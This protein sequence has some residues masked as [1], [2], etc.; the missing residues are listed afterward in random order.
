MMQP[1]QTPSSAS[2]SSETQPKLHIHFRF[3][4]VFLVGA[5]IYAVFM[6]GFLV[7]VNRTIKPSQAGAPTPAANTADAVSK[8]TVRLVFELRKIGED[9][10]PTRIDALPSSLVET[11][12]Q[13]KNI[14]LK[15][16]R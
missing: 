15:E 11:A 8:A 3:L 1:D 6:F 4:V 12:R 5:L 16:L 2:E 14:L 10:L 13:R 7:N 9:N